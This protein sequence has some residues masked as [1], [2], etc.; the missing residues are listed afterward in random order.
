M[1]GASPNRETASTSRLKMQTKASNS[2]D[3]NHVYPPLVDSTAGLKSF[4]NVAAASTGPVTG[5]LC[6]FRADCAP[7]CFAAEVVARGVA[8]SRPRRRRA[9]AGVPGHEPGCHVV[10]D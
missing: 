10:G 5:G 6:I 9:E 7:V 8:G 4:Q 3:N 2:S 1:I